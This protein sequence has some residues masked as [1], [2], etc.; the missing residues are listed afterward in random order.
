MNRLDR[1]FAVVDASAD[2]NHLISTCDQTVYYVGPKTLPI[3]E[4]SGELAEKLLDS[5]NDEEGI[6]DLND[7]DIP[8]ALT[9][10]V[11]LENRYGSP[12]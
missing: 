3:D 6:D 10:F 1:G 5:D 2:N 8:T 9:H 7:I 11:K 12:L 4:E